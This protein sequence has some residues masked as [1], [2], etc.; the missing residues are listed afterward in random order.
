MKNVISKNRPCLYVRA[1]IDVTRKG[2]K[3]G[4]RRHLSIQLS[5]SFPTVNINFYHKDILQCWAVS[6][7][8]LLPP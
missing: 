8:A 6:V 3:S 1:S 4:L 5:R 7:Q 2:Y